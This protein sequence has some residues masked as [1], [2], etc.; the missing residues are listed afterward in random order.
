MSGI[1]SCPQK[2]GKVLFRTDRRRGPAGVDP[3]QPAQPARSARSRAAE[4]R[5]TRHPPGRSRGAS[6]STGAHLQSSPGH[7]PTP[8]VDLDN[9][10]R[11]L[12]LRVL[13]DFEVRDAASLATLAEAC[14]ALDLLEAA[15][16]E[17]RH[18]GVTFKDRWKQPRPHPAAQVVR[19]S[20]AGSRS[21]CRATQDGD[22]PLA[23]TSSQAPAPEC[24]LPAPPN[25]RED[26]CIG[27][28]TA[29][30]TPTR[31]SCRPLPRGHSLPTPCQYGDST[32]LTF[33]L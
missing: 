3:P 16:A 2:S 18:D 33:Y 31:A 21:A 14:H 23:C 5:S 9:A 13:A 15:R 24:G 7:P 4:R 32:P 20:R 10:G 12:W 29:S 28:A 8:P 17:L 6:T 27:G 25:A 11:A 1:L 26:P 19:D 30:D 22:P